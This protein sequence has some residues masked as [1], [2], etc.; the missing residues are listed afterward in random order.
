M[1]KVRKTNKKREYVLLGPKVPFEIV[2]SYKELRTNLIFVLGARNSKV[3][4]F[5]SA[6]MMEGKTNT[7]ANVAIT[8]AQM[9]ARVLLIDADMRK[10]RLHRLFGCTLG[11]GL[12]EALCGVIE[13]SSIQKTAYDNLFVMTAGR[14]P[15]NPADLLY[16]PNMDTLLE[17]VQNTFDYVFIDAPPVGVVTDA[18]IIAAKIDGAIMVVRDGQSRVDNINAARDALNSAGT[19]VIGY[20][21]TDADNKNKGY[22]NNYRGYG[23]AYY[24]SQEQ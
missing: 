19:G 1:F 9:G 15:P 4:M 6:L 14:I 23:S 5:T 18:A 7:S 13:D 16:S 10:P 2:E 11:T 21:L 24:S 17:T 20:V 12:S 22:T 3:A 8:F